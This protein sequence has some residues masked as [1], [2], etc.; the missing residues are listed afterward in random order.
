MRFTAT[1]ILLA[2]LV[3]CLP[4]NAQP[5]PDMEKKW[6]SVVIPKIKMNF[7]KE[8]LPLQ[9]KHSAKIVLVAR[10][11]LEKDGAVRNLRIDRTEEETDLPKAEQLLLEKALLKAIKKSVPL[12]YG[13]RPDSL[14]RH[15]GL[16]VRYEAA[17]NKLEAGMTH[18]E[19]VPG[20]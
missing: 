18:P 11:Y 14:L 3:A 16:Y 9:I 13:N 6:E 7:D 8:F 2:S 19:D 12:P 20:P 5:T 17:K 1:S 10:A 15:V 4:T